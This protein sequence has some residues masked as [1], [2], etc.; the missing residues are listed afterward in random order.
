ML[1]HPVWLKNSI[2]YWFSKIK[3]E[4][5]A[6]HVTFGFQ[7]W[8]LKAIFFS[9]LNFF[10]PYWSSNQISI[11]FGWALTNISRQAKSRPMFHLMSILSLDLINGFWTGPNK[12]PIKMGTSLEFMNCTCTQSISW[13]PSVKCCVLNTVFGGEHLR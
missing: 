13:I 4:L 5:L 2:F 9:E 6:Q 1:G 8:N 12:A 11:S 10:Y 7:S 3:S